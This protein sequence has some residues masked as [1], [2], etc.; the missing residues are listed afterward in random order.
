MKQLF[1]YTTL[2]TVIFVM[3]SCVT[4]I[5][6]FEQI[7]G[8]SLLTIEAI[9]SNQEGPH[10]IL[11]SYSSP[12][13]S[14][15]VENTPIR[16][17]R[18]YITDDKNKRQD[19]TESIAGTY[20]TSSTFKGIVG[21]IYTLHV[22]L[23]NGKKYQSTPEKLLPVP[24]ID[25]IN[26]KF[27]VKTNYPLTDA[28]SVGFDVTLDFKDA[29]EPNQ[30][31]QW[32][33]THIE[34]AVYCAFCTN[35]FDFDK[36]RCTV[37]LNFNGRAELL[38]YQCVSSCFDIVFSSTYNILSD[39]LFN[40]QKIVNYPIARVPFSSYSLY[41]LKIEQ[42]AISEKLFKYFRSIKS[43]TQNT[44]TL[45]DVPSETQYS[46]NIY[47]L[48]N[49]NEKILGAFEV[50][51]SQEKVIYIDRLSGTNGFSPVRVRGLGKDIT[52]SPKAACI[53]G[54]YRT[55]IEPKDF[56]E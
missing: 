43:G 11:I 22:D 56:R 17:A 18:V 21:N 53:E 12:S 34:R 5:R 14:I 29:P 25:K 24:V 6:D 3:F 39:N 41:Y 2:L 40:G 52:P 51:G 8:N 54:K 26:S 48:D 20:L 15:N 45:F 33:W 38:N 23:Q 1:R 49:K 50:F 9:L 32:K 44:G 10:K 30:F 31:Y 27:A 13:I 19:L 7:E 55:K 42:R 16:N 28:R 46:P 47:S 37:D 36:G 4:E 35:G